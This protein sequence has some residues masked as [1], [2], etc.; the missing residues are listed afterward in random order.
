MDKN[1]PDDTN[2]NP[3]WDAALGSDTNTGVLRLLLG[4][5]VFFAAGALASF[6][7]A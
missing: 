3:I 2:V 4:L 5:L 7:I 1:S 6:L